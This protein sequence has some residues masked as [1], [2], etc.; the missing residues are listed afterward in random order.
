MSN[1]RTKLIKAA[2]Y[3]LGTLA[4]LAFLI[5]KNP[6]ALAW[7]TS[8]SYRYGDLYRFAQINRFKPAHPLPTGSVENRDSLDQG[9]TLQASD[10]LILLG[11]SFSFA[12]WG[13]STFSI[14]LAHKTGLSL[15]SIDNNHHPEFW[16]NP[17]RLLETYAN[18]PTPSR[19]VVYEIAERL[20]EQQFS[21][22]VPSAATAGPALLMPTHLNA[23]RKIED[24]I[25]GDT[26]SRHETLLKHS[27]ITSPI[28]SLWNTTIFE[29]FQ[30]ISVHT[31]L[32]SLEPP[33]LFFREEVNCYQTVHS[34]HLVTALAD[35]ITQLSE[36]LRTRYNCTLVFVPVPNK[37]TVYSQLATAKPYD[38]FLPRL[39]A[40]LKTRNVHTVELLQ[41][42]KQEKDFLYWPSD[43]HWN[44]LGIRMA[45]EETMRE[46]PRL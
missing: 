2:L 39:C 35:N 13:E 16:R 15:F 33:F 38:D 30:Q 23:F 4:G 25:L 37:I 3:V 5:T 8:D 28:V 14:Q 7:A 46:L 40:V 26:E 41:R 18:Q 42:F 9:Q 43:T 22:P 6:T 17:Y 24:A 27:F 32:Y 44:N 31:P 1:T 34:E 19:I 36:T 11:D 10:K 29:N 21:I 12:D 20:I 45:V